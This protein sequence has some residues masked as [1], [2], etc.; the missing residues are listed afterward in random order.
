MAISRAI[1]RVAEAGAMLVERTIS[2][3]MRQRELQ[4][5]EKVLNERKAELLGEAVRTASGMGDAREQF[6]DP[7]DRAGL[8]GDR[9]LMLR[10]RDRERKLIGKIDEALGRIEDGSYGK[11]EECGREIG[12]ARLKVRPVTTLCIECKEEQEAE[13]RRRKSG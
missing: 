11:C 1:Y 2:S 4:I 12:F 6:A 13:E 3:V 5:L 8:E 9:N 7:T 10:I